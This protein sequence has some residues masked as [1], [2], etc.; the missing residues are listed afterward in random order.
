MWTRRT[1]ATLT[2]VLATGLL[3]GC[4]MR[5]S[6]GALLGAGVGA[7]AGAAIGGD[8][9]SAIVGSAVGA[10]IGYEVDYHDGG[11]G[12][13]GYRYY[14]GYRHDCRPRRRHHRRHY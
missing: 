5:G 12:Y 2:L 10:S 1:L 3:S 14:D 8:A 11:Y 13:Y 6:H 7:L 9:G 4:S